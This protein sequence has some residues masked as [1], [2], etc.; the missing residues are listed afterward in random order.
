MSEP[1]T[2]AVSVPAS[3]RITGA[4]AVAADGTPLKA[5]VRETLTSG[6]AI[7]FVRQWEADVE[8]RK[9]R[10]AICAR[11]PNRMIEAVERFA[12]DALRIS[13]HGATEIT[14]S[15]G[16]FRRIYDEAAGMLVD[17]PRALNEPPPMRYDT[18][19]TIEIA[20]VAGLVRVRRGP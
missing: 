19:V 18:P 1:Y 20:T 4:V 15:R 2:G 10:E 6:S 16:A 13:G 5:E 3:V 7:A 14:L 9:E 12:I 11:Q 17:S 8:A